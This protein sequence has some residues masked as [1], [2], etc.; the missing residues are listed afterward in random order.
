MTNKENVF[1]FIKTNDK[2]AN[3]VMVF[4]EENKIDYAYF[5]NIEELFEYYDE[6][7]YK[8]FSSMIIDVI[9]ETGELIKILN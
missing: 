5:I 4:C 1:E 3:E 2:T 8:S 6:D 7:N 9:C